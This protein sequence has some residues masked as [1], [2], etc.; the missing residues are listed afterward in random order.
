MQLKGFKMII[1]RLFLCL[2]LSPLFFSFNA[3]AEAAPP[4][5]EVDVAYPL[6][7]K[8]V[9]WDEYTGRFRAMEEVEVRARVTGY[10]DAIKFKDGQKVKKG[11][12]LFVI[13]PRPFFQFVLDR[14]KAQHELA[15]KQYKRRSNYKKKFSSDEVIDQR[16]EEMQVAATRVDEAKLNLEFTEVQ[17]PIS[18]KISRNFVSIGNLITKNDTIL[19]RIVS[20]DPIYFYFE[21]S[22][23]DL[24]KYIRLDRAGR[25]PSTDKIAHP[26]KIKLQDEND[27]VHK[28]KTDFV[29]NIVDRG[30]GTII[31]RAVVPNPDDIIYPGIFGR[32]RLAGS[33]FYE[34]LL[35]PDKAINTDQSRKFVY[36]VDKNNQ[37]QRVYVKLGDIRDS[38]YYIIEEGLKGNE[39]VV[40]SGVQ[41]IRSPEQ[42]VKPIMI[43]LSE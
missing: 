35:L 36:V 4:L 16:F 34:A 17:S 28:G 41:R 20:F 22:Q 15:Q 38:G 9:E 3:V 40:I 26:I 10:L 13:D 37:V 42:K 8:I 31:T 19:T 27:Y 5:A 33:G 6:K 14:M 32:A 12:V 39:R 1:Q 23:N 29:D 25:R 18:G 2:L 30:T 21:I 11:D 24:L 7:K 43:Q